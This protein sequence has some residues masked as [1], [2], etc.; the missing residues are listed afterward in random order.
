MALKFKT[1]NDFDFNGKTVILRVDINSPLDPQTLEIIDDSRIR[2]HSETINE[3]LE[4]N[5]KVVILGHQGRKGDPDFTDFSR[6][7]KAMLKYVK[8]LKYVNDIV[9]VTAINAVR[10][11]KPGEALLLENVRMLNEE[12]ETKTAEEHAK[13]T[14]VS[15]LAPLADF[16]VNDA[17]SASHRAHASIIGFTAVLPSVAGRVMER[18]LKALEKVVDNP[19]KPCLYVLGG[20]KAK[21]TFKVIENV[22][23]K[24]IADKVLLGGMIAQ[25]F[26]EAAGFRLGSVNSRLIEEKGLGKFRENASK[27]LSKH[28]QKVML[29]YDYAVDIDGDRVEYMVSQLPVEYPLKDIGSETIRVYRREIGNASTIVFNG[30]VGVFEEEA[31]AKGTIEL[32]KAAASSKAFT[33]VGGGHSISA[34][35]KAGVY[36]KIGFVSTA[37]GALISYLSGEKLPGVEALKTQ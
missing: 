31:F 6:H 3:L 37:G 14:L 35:E 13:G 32:Y 9:G 1:L 16:F 18:E 23:D 36:D 17:F 7:Y 29:P 8:N 25:V 30:P 22:L 33:V 28:S 34:L 26:H 15:T 27:I 12:T 11:L 24:G 5:A 10:E 19:S 20:A 21:E 4:K 2:E